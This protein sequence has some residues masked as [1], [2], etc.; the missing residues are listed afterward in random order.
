MPPPFSMLKY[1]KEIDRLERAYNVHFN[2]LWNMVSKAKFTLMKR[3][4]ETIAI[5]VKHVYDI[6]NRDLESWLKAVMAPLETQVREHHM[7]L[8][9]RLESVKRIHRASDELEER[10]V[11]LEQAEAGVRAQNDALIREIA[12][13]DAVIEQ[14][15]LLPLAANA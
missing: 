7:Q 14:P 10:I 2:T 1:Q 13:I 3:F 6:A 4:F 11:E 12:A 15:D 5:R 9:R 8:R